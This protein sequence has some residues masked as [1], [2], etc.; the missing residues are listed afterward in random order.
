VV[1]E[2]GCGGCVRALWWWCWWRDAVVVVVVVEQQL[3]WGEE[4]AL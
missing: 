4:L 3:G 2:T 1:V